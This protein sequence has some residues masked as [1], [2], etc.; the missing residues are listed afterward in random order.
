MG[1]CIQC[2]NKNCYEAFHVT[3]AR[4]ARLFL[5]MK[6]THGSGILDASILKAF[7][8]RHSPPEWKRE[9]DVESATED[10]KAF[11]RQ[12][13]RG[14]R[15]GD[16][17]QV[18]LGS[19]VAALSLAEGAEGQGADEPTAAMGSNKRKRGQS[20]T[21]IWRLPSGAP[22]VPFIVFH[23]VENAMAKFSIRKRKEYVA[24]ACKY[25]TL[26]REARRG[27]A[28]LK[29]LQ[30]Q[31]ETF[32]SMEITRRNFA[33]MGAVGGP[34]LERRIAFVDRLEED[35]GHIRELC[36]KIMER[37]AKKLEDVQILRTI[38]DSIYSPLTPLLWE[39]FEKAVK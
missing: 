5:K 1:A 24:E 17:Q 10:A 29:R 31:M 37:E 16:S 33:G 38:V 36:L 18:A 35:M 19:G 9:H 25:W 22:I 39:V 6:S 15:W 4:K 14:R 28:L 7:C 20:Q 27:A 12:T 2:G 34:K 26:K 30:L 11:Y 13:M 23:N 3:C 21:N 32:T 8:H